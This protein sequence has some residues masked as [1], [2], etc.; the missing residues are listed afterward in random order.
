MFNFFKRKDE[1]VGV[2]IERIEQCK[3]IVPEEVRQ[4]SD[5][6]FDYLSGIV[7][8]HWTNEHIADY[9]AQKH[10]YTTSLP[11]HVAIGWNRGS[12]ISI[13]EY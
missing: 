3:K 12:T 11:M 2:L 5:P 4:I 13:A 6:L 1:T 7:K 9:K 8:S 10:S